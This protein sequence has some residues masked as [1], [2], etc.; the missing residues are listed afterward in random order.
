MNATDDES[1]DGTQEEPLNPE[2]LNAEP[3]NIDRLCQIFREQ[4]VACLHESARGRSGLF[5]DTVAGQGKW[6]EAEQLRALAVAL[7]SMMAQLRLESPGGALL[8]QYLDLCSM[9]G[10]SHPGEAR[11][12]RQFLDWM[13]A[14]R[15]QP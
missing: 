13:D 7:H 2:P 3:L 6:P 14:A 8:D 5:S 15:E 11:L 9:H 12:A 4:L 10:E 1:L